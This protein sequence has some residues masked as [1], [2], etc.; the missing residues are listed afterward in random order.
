VEI[1]FW[2]LALTILHS[3]IFYPLLLRV[4]VLFAART[5]EQHFSQQEYPSISII[6]A[7]HNEE[8]VIGQKIDSIYNTTYPTSKIEVFVG[9][10]CSTD[11]T[12]QI[13]AEKAKQYPLLSYKAF[14]Q[15]Q[16]K[17]NIMNQLLDCTKGDIII[18]T[19]AN[20]M[21]CPTTLEEMVKPF[22]DPQIG[23]V[24]SQM[25]NTGIKKEG[26]STQESQYITREVGIKH[27]EGKVWGTMM[28]P[29]GGCFAIRKKCYSKVPTNYFMDDFYINMK[30]LEQG[31]KSINALDAIVKEDVSNQIKEE[32]KRKTRI[33]IGNFQNLFT[34]T[35]LLWPPFTGLAFSFVSHKII[36]WFGPF[37]IV[38]CW[39]LA[40]ILIK[41]HPIYA[42]IFWAL[43]G[44]FLVPLFDF[45]LKK[46]NIH[47][48]FVRFVTHFY[49]MNLALMVGFF[50]YLKGV[51]SNV[52]QPTK[53]NQ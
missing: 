11:K 18:S 9:S 30:V 31:Y 15:R 35:H 26:I 8:N 23:L 52:W 49:G 28:G 13:L 38:A 25:T 48:I 2:I 41:E 37:I 32:F 20:V 51:N 6:M 10:D 21:L 19:D 45:L 39:V 14:T 17:A 24:D 4:L 12:N 44:S 42:A 40:L 47:I 33:S 16:G 5:K 7:A 53:R 27:R 50:K 34:F 43:S 3:Y 22:K 46:C 29:F 36:R 1:V